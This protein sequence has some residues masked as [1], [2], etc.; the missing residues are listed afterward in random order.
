MVGSDCRRG[1]Y[2]QTIIARE[3]EKRH[4][5]IWAHGRSVTGN[6]G[7]NSDPRRGSR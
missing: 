5:R 6:H 1:H 2:A 3:L 4:A 7:L